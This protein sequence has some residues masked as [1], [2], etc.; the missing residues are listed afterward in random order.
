[1]SM[2]NKF[3]Q[4]SDNILFRRLEDSGVTMAC[5]IF[6]IYLFILEHN[7]PVAKRQGRMKKAPTF[8]MGSIHKQNLTN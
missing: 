6:F 5:W 4:R 1:M 3:S 7:D 8:E 2:Q